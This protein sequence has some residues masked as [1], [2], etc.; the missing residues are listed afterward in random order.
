FCRILRHRDRCWLTVGGQAPGEL[1]QA[2]SRPE[3]VRVLAATAPV[4]HALVDGLCV[5]PDPEVLAEWRASQPPDRRRRGRTVVDDGRVG[6]LAWHYCRIPSVRADAWC[7]P[8]GLPPLGYLLDF[9]LREK[10]GL[11]LEKDALGGRCGYPFDVQP[12]GV[13]VRLF[14][15]RRE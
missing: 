8:G 1:R 12:D 2:V 10:A 13:R 3:C 6:S 5:Q 14:P 7:V 9:S 15:A 4:S 11:R